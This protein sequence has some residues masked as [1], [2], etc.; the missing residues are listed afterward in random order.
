MLFLKRIFLLIEIKKCLVVNKLKKIDTLA[1]LITIGF[2]LYLLMSSIHAGNLFKYF[3]SDLQNKQNSIEFIKIFSLMLFVMYIINIFTPLSI[4]GFNKKTDLVSILV[5]H[6]FTVKEIV[7][8]SIIVEFSSIFILLF[9]PFYIAS[10]FIINHSVQF[11]EVILFTVV[12]LSFMFSVSA[13]VVLIRNIFQELLK[14]KILRKIFFG[15]T[16]TTYILL[17]IFYFYQTTEPKNIDVSKVMQ[18]IRYAPPGILSDYIMHR[19][20]FINALLYFIPVNI[21][22]LCLNFYFVKRYNKKAN[23]AQ[24]KNNQKMH[25]FK[26]WIFDK[27][28]INGYIQK[29]LCYLFRSPRTI[30]NLILWI[31][32]LATG[33]FPISDKYSL[34]IFPV[35]LL[36]VTSFLFGINVFAYEYAGI[37]NY[38][39]RPISA[40]EVLKNKEK[41]FTF[42]VYIL[43]I[44]L[45]VLVLV[46]KEI[47]NI[48]DS[49][50]FISTFMAHYY[51]C[52]YCGLFISIYSP[53]RINFYVISGRSVSFITMFFLLILIGF[54]AGIEACFMLLY[55]KLPS[56]VLINIITTVIAYVM[57]KS[58]RTVFDRL[59][60]MFNKRKERNI[61]ACQ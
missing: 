34:F 36:Y 30:L 21:T 14:R 37:V 40:F 5:Y 33:L 31:F 50:F 59:A 55:S 46:K 47:P 52:I 61:L 24:V 3:M 20:S 16:I 23:T 44:V 60:N 45:S 35:L 38:F 49:I 10:F 12:L 43:I 4:G 7:F 25:L 32:L 28:K 15:L 6:P 1:L 22:L 56:H 26:M 48:S 53:Y 27:L 58:R 42:F 13:A 54:G 41:S 18:I 39:Y 57:F 17:I 9:I 29:D 2:G 51:I 8:Y 11:V 19:L